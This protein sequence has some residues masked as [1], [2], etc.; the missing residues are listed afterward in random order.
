MKLI[1]G[2][3]NEVRRDD[4]VGVVIANQFIAEEPPD[5]W[6]IIT[7]HQLMPEHAYDVAAAEQVVFVD[8][9][10][11]GRPGNVTMTELAPSTHMEDAHALTPPGVLRLAV[12]LYDAHPTAHLVTVTGADFELGTGLSDVVAAAVPVAIKT[13]CERMR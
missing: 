11:E 2:Y 4:G 12:T 1:I 10:I 9:S 6:R 8:A 7:A 13:I 3:G 5:D